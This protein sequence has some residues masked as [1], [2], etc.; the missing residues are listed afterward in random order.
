VSASV[1]W[2]LLPPE[3]G[4]GFLHFLA[5]FLLAQI[6]G[7][8]SQVPGGL[9]V[10]E[11]VVISLLPAGV[12]TSV[13]LG[14]LVAYRVVYYLLPLVVAVGVLL[15]YELM[16]RRQQIGKVSSVVGVGLNLVAPRLLAL[17]SFLGGAMLLV[18]GATPAGADRLRWLDELVPLAALELSHFLASV[19]GVLLLLLA[20]GLQRRLESA[21]YLT[22]VALGSGAILSLLRGVD[23]EAATV[24]VAMIAALAPTRRFFYRKTPL[25]NEPLS[26]DWLA[27]VAM[28][29]VGAFWIGLFA[30]RHVDYSTE[31]WWQFTLDGDASRFLRGGVGVAVGLL[32]FGVARLLGPSAPRE[33]ELSA[34]EEQLVRTIVSSSPHASANLALIGDKRF[35]FSPSGRSMIMYAVHGRS[36]IAMGEPIGPEEE[37]VDLVWSFHALCDRHGGWTVFYEVSEDHLSL[38]LELG[39]T[40]LRIG[41]EGT[42]PLE[43]FSLEGSSH[44]ELRHVRHK[45]ERDGCSFDVGAAT[46]VPA[47][48]P[49]L[50]EIS[51]A[52]LEDKH[53]REKGFSLGRFDDSY[54]SQFPLALVRQHGRIVAF[55]NV[56]QGAP[57]GELSIDLMRHLPDAPRGVMDFLFTHLMEWGRDHGF[58]TF[59]LGMAPLAGLRAGP[60]ATLWNRLAS[61]AYRHGEY[62]YN[63]QGL[64]NYK[65]KFDPEWQPRYLVCPG[66]RAVP[67]VLADLAAL[68]SGGLLGAIRK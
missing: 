21:Y 6:L 58:A 63:F 52:W 48:L 11:T 37:H 68:I 45:L 19:V 24:L 22:L 34:E 55:A 65:D 14:P 31:L 13:V 15:V 54:M 46:A 10:F 20:W 27:A 49:E 61:L 57:G 29:L 39:L 62:F 32:A 8:V 38:F 7:L 5:V 36:W 42:V 16:R 26:T 66:G 1:L 67:G 30:Y 44:K 9:G 33:R 60:F 18:A 47:L 53:S 41:E 50:R 59:G 12:D 51:D 2:V 56:W 40:A 35:C 4:I 43:R 28:A 64:R 17:S 3:L 23:Y 25:L